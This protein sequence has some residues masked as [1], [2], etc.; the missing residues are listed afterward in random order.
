MKSKKWRILLF[1][2]AL[3]MVVNNVTAQEPKP[4]PEEIDVLCCRSPAFDEDFY[5]RKVIE[6]GDTKAYDTLSSFFLVNYKIVPP[7]DQVYFNDN[8]RYALIMANKYHY[9]N[10]YTHVYEYITW[11]YEN[12]NMSMDSVT[13]NFAFHYLQKGGELGSQKAHLI[14]WTLYWMGNQYVPKDSVMAEIWETK[15]FEKGPLKRVS[16]ST[17]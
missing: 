13:W 4:E 7:E 8:L 6:T 5:R 2:T 10:A 3:V 9:P 16:K 1:A 15:F 14:L 17:K 12:N 11:I